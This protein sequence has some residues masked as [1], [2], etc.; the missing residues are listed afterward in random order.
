MRCTKSKEGVTCDQPPTSEEHLIPQVSE[1]LEKLALSEQVVMQVLDVL[2][3]GHDDI[4]LY[5]Q[6]AVKETR[7]II[8]KL[9]KT[10]ERD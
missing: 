4:R 10:L 7:T 9:N 2:K 6:T 3:K 5:Y 1:L 8:E